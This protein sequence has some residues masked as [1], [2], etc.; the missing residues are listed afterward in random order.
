[1]DLAEALAV[2]EMARN[3]ELHVADADSATWIARL[4]SIVDDIE[5]AVRRLIEADRVGDALD[6]V[7]ALSVFWQDVGK[8]ETG[9]RLTEAAIAAATRSPGD[10]PMARAMLALGELAFRQADQQSASSATE[11][12]AAIAAEIGDEWI[13]GR[14]ALNM[15]RIAFRDG[16]A[17]RIAEH[18]RNVLGIAR[19]NLRLR[20]GAIHMLGW[21]EYTAGN[22]QAALSRFEENAGLYAAMGDAIDEAGE[23]ANVADLLMEAGDLGGAAARL[24]RALDIREASSSRYLAP[25]LIRSA[26]VLAGGRGDHTAALRLIAGA[27]ALYEEF[28]L[29]GDPGDNVTSAAREAATVALGE[30]RAST[31]IEAVRGLE[32]SVLIDESRRILDL[33]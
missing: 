20:S 29:V 3:V 27:E 33:D 8:V 2:L 5:P 28:G 31:I 17:T 10:R 24:R 21:A 14:A 12:A 7:G 4:E 19:D 26:G 13:S 9:R 23:W 16:D 30:A 15:A 1:V 22:L 6:L 25:S 18:A 11:H 32:L